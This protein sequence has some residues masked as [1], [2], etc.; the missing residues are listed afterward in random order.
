MEPSCSDEQGNAIESKCLIISCCPGIFT[1]RKTKE[2]S[3]THHIGNHSAFRRWIGSVGKMESVDYQCDWHGLDTDRR[4]VGIFKQPQLGLNTIT[5]HS[6][7]RFPGVLGSHPSEFLCHGKEGVRNCFNP[8]GLTTWGNS[9]VSVSG[10]E[11]LQ[12]GDRI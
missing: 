9:T 3:N 8:D 6:V 1:W 2:E 5:N 10:S 7:R 11:D 4:R 12:V